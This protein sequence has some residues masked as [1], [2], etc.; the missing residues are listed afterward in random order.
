MAASAALG[1]LA[2]CN[3]LFYFPS[4]E[5]LGRSKHPHRDVRFTSSDGTHL[6][7]WY[8][9]SLHAPAR[10]TIVQLHGNAGNVTSHADQLDW[11]VAHG[12]A[13]FTFDY[14]GYGQSDAVDPTREGVHRDATSA[15]KYAI[16]EYSS[17]PLIVYGQSLGGAVAIAALAEVDRTNVA[18]LIVEGTFHSYQDA[19]ATVVWRSGLGAPLTGAAYWWITEDHAPYRVIGRLSPTP[20]LVIHGTD[21]PVVRYDLGLV[22]YELAKQPKE[23]WGIPGG[24]HVDVTT[25]DDGAYRPRLVDWIERTLASHARSNGPS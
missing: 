5:V 24:G 2:G 23:F 19:A 12:F 21:D 22:V 15:L 1:A 9:P 8:F 10:A 7:G 16:A 11:V 4:Q 17:A 25:R 3:H 14:R 6:H 18:G 13:F 20:V